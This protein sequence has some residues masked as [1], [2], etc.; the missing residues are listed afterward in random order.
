MPRRGS[1]T[2]HT[3]DGI[4]DR[5]IHASEGRA[6]ALSLRSNFSWTFAGTLVYTLCQW[7]MLSVLSKLG[8]PVAVG[9]FALGLA[10]TAPVILFSNLQLRSVQATDTRGE[11][12]F[13]DYLGLRIATILLALVLISTIVL[14]S[15][16]RIEIILLVL[17]VGVAKAFEAMSDI[18]YGL[19]Q[20]Y[21]RM[22]VVAR[23]M[24]IKGPLSLLAL[25][26]VF[27]LT[28]DVMW[29][30]V[31]MT[32]AW[33]LVLFAYDVRKT[34]LLNQQR[35]R[36]E[37]MRL[38]PRWKVGALWQ[39][40]YFALPLGFVAALNS[41]HINLPR[42]LTEQY[43]GERE[44]GI[45]AALAYIM[46]SARLVSG[47]LGNS[48]SPR[49]ARFYAE[50]DRAAFSRLLLRLVLIGVLAGVAGVLAA[51]VAGRWILSVLYTS[52]YANY[53]GLLVCI[54]VATGINYVT[55]VLNFG[56]V[57]VRRFRIQ[58]LALVGVVATTSIACLILIPS[59]GV[60]G[61]GMALTLGMAFY[62]LADCLIMLHVLRKLPGGMARS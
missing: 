32:V 15:G 41:L 36:E 33:I 21:E 38:G 8:T 11:Y 6:G 51:L 43:L 54:M 26:F 42:Y 61:A 59:F 37:G 20:Q 39:L 19:L 45:F 29:A 62:L 58:A 24:M 16:Y 14:L 22:D 9:Q 2:E 60:L 27:Y 49:L 13:G 1:G 28:R 23:S 5:G 17:V 55:S 7:G 30:A 25:G 3:I 57:A 50:G 47:A 31:A 46:V 10:I 4:P 44:L 56:I 40:A 34:V 18:F 52:E 35:M 48:A 53:T 12:T